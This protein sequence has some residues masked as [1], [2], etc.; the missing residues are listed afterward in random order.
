MRTEM[1]MENERVDL[2]ADLSALLTFS[3]D[4]VKEFAARS[5][6]F[7]KTIVLPG[8][9]RNNRL[10]G[11][12][13]QTGQANWYNA[14]QPN[15]GYNFNAAKSANCIIFQ[16]HLQTFKG[17][18][19]LL[20]I[21]C[22]KGR[23]EYEVA[24][25]GEIAL[26]NSTLAGALLEDLDFSEHDHDY[27]I[28]NIADSWDNPGGSGVYYPLIDYGTYS[29]DKQNWNYR[30]FRPALY[31]REYLDKIFTAAGFRYDAP[32]FDTPRFKSIIIPHNKKDLTRKDGPFL[33]ATMNTPADILYSAIGK[34]TPQDAVLETFSASNF[35]ID[36]TNKFITYTGITPVT[37]RGRV[38]V[39]GDIFNGTTDEVRM[40]LGPL[41]AG[42]GDT[43]SVVLPPPNP[44]LQATPFT[45]DETREVT[46]FPGGIYSFR[47]YIQDPTGTPYR[48]RI[49]SID[50]SLD[51]VTPIYEIVDLGEPVKMNEQIPQNVKQVDFLLA[52]IR[53]WNLYVYED[54]NDTRLIR[55]NPFVDFYGTDSINSVDWSFKLNR[56]KVFTLEPLSE[57]NAKKYGF[58]YKADNDFYN[59]EYR[60]RWGEGYGDYTFDSQFEF[61]EQVKS[62]EVVFSATPLV[63]YVGEDKVYSTIMK[64]TGEG[65]SLIE[66]RIDSNIRLL[67]TKKITGVNNWDIMSDTGD[68]LGLFD[69][70]PYAGHLNDPDVPTDCLNF[71]ALRS[72]FFV[73]AAIPAYATQF[74]AYWSPYMAEITD[75][76]GKLLT[77]NFYLTA[78]DIAELDFSRLIYVDGSLFRLNKIA[79]YNASKPSDCK[80][81]LLKVNYLLY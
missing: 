53:L 23:I 15:I 64:R 28:D 46:L 72:V 50:I 16:D 18:L 17:V 40:D 45:F 36:G 61:S 76:D 54:F 5:T 22:E 70:Y 65:G 19:R 43:G 49:F 11:N 51:A 66:E 39:T 10:F 58:K 74:K 41:S 27:T 1:Y 38:R 60:K 34:T 71:G 48:T 4:D 21:V 32:L 12:I 2:T 24:V 47:H 81:E 44:A 25:F 67:Q 20:K 35:T 29:T 8:T 75:K 69:L 68:S 7:S 26:L 9:A 56:D 52:V 59:E 77:G 63:G 14:G 13:F 30:T 78:K 80:C 31:L 33:R 55:I 6:T 3:L 37:V 42:S 79:D 73:I 57:L 62:F